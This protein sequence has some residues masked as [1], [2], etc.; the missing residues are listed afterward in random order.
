MHE[1]LI[2]IEAKLKAIEKNIGTET[3]PIIVKTIKEV[4]IDDG[5][6]DNK[7]NLQLPAVYFDI[8]EM[9]YSQAAENIGLADTE[10]TLKLLVRKND[11][12]RYDIIDQITQALVGSHGETF[13]NLLKESQRKTSYDDIFEY[14]ITFGCIL[15]DIAAVP[16]YIKLEDEKLPELN[17][18]Y[19]MKIPGI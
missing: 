10:I 17:L 5:Q 13:G 3:E 4:A 11:S 1:L 8:T 7:I 9:A 18:N 19:K 16:E 14:T 15:Y 2:H 6:A 12:T